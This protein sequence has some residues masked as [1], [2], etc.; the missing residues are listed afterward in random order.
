[1]KNRNQLFPW[2]IFA[3]LACGSHLLAQS[4]TL[5][6]SA[7]T[8]TVTA[9][10]SVQAVA[11]ITVTRTGG[12]TGAASISYTSWIGNENTAT[13]WNSS[14]GINPDLYSG[15]LTV[16]SGILNWAA[17][18]SAPKTFDVLLEQR[19]AGTYNGDGMLNL[20]IENASGATLGTTSRAMLTVKDPSPPAAGVLKFSRR[21]YFANRTTGTATITVSRSGGS[22]GTVGISY[23]TNATV[24]PWLSGFSNPLPP[25]ASTSSDYTPT[26]GT[27]SWGPGDLADKSFTIPLNVGG[28]GTNEVIGL[29]LSSPTGGAVLGNAPAAACT[30]VNPSANVV[31]LYQQG[32]GFQTRIWLPPAGTPL[33]GILFHMPG[34]SN[35]TLGVCNDY[36]W[37]QM[38]GSLGLAIM[39]FQSSAI[40]SEDA[41]G[42]GDLLNML[43]TAADYTGRAEL[44]NAPVIYTGFSSGGFCSNSS[45]FI[46]SRRVISYFSYKGG[47]WPVDGGN[48]PLQV[49]D[50]PRTMDAVQ[51]MIPGFYVTGNSDTTV[52]PGRSNI[53]F[54]PRRAQGAQVAYGVDWGTG[55][56]VFGAGSGEAMMW[57][58]LGEVVPLRF[59][60]TGR[61]V[62][63]P[64]AG[65]TV[66]LQDIPDSAGWI[67][68]HS[69]TFSTTNKDGLITGGFSTLPPITPYASYSG[70]KLAANWLPSATVA[71]AFQAFNARQTPVG[72]GN[73]NIANQ[74]LNTPLKFLS[75]ASLA[76][77]VLGQTYPIEINPRRVTNLKRIRFYEGDTLI[78]ERTAA[79]WKIDWTPS[80]A[81]VRTLTVIGTDSNNQ[82]IPAFNA[83]SVQ[84]LSSPG[85][86]Q[87]QAAT[88]EAFRSAGNATFVINRS[89]GKAGAVGATWAISGGTAVSGTDFSGPTSGSVTWADGD[90]TPKTISIPLL[91]STPRL[92]RTIDLTL[93]SLTG[94]IALAPARDNTD[95]AP[96]DTRRATSTITIHDDTSPLPSPWSTTTIG[97]TIG[98]GIP[99]EAS[100]FAENTFSL[101]AAT[102]QYWGSSDWL[103]FA[104]QPMTGDCSITARVSSMTAGG[105]FPRAG[106]M[107]RQDLS[108]TSAFCGAQAASGNT[109]V[110]LYRTTG[111]SGTANTSGPTLTIPNA[112]FRVTR[113][114]N[115]LTSFTSPNGSTWTQLGTP[116]TITMTGTVYVGLVW[117]NG[118]A[119]A[120]STEARFDNVSVTGTA[121]ATAVPVITGTPLAAITGYAGEY[122]SRTIVATGNPTPTFSIASGTLPAGLT[123]N[124]VTGVLSGSPQATGSTSVTIRA[125]NAVGTNDA[126]Q[127][128]SIALLVPPVIS[129]SA[130]PTTPQSQAVS[131]QLAASNS[132]T[133][134][135]MTG[136]SLP[137]GVSFNAATA[138]ISGTPSQTG[139]FRPVFTATNSAGTSSPKTVAM[140]IVAAL[141]PSV[142]YDFN[143]TQAD[144]NT[145]FL[146]TQ[147]GGTPTWASAGI[148]A[149]G[150]V[151]NT[152]WLAASS[153]TQTALWNQG[154]QWLPG[155]T[156]TVS[157]YFK[158]RVTAGSVAGGSSLRL[159]YTDDNL[160]ILTGA[161]YLSV[162]IN[163][164]AGDQSQLAVIYRQG[165]TITTAGPNVGTLVH[166]NWY[167]LI[168]TFTKSASSGSFD[169]VVSLK[170]WGADGQ[171]GGTVLGTSSSIAAT[172][173]TNVYD[174][175]GV[176]AGFVGTT[177]SSSGVQGFDS[178]SVAIPVP[179]PAVVPG[180]AFNA[181][182]GVT[183]S[184]SVAATGNPVAYTL[185]SGSLPA[186]LSLNTSTGAITGT[187]TASGTFAPLISATNLGGGESA[188]EAVNITILSGLD[189]YRAV[190]GLSANGSQDLLTPAGDGVANL[191]KYAFNMIG[192]GT[193]QA[194][195]L[196]T[197]NASVLTPSGSAGLP[198]VSLLPAPSSSL[199]LTFIRRKASSA[200][201]I[202]YTVEFSDALATWAVNP[203]ATESVTSLDATFERVTVTDSVAAPDKRF[204]RVK[205]TAP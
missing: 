88:P 52:E 28:T 105:S 140:N 90:A 34:T 106:V 47:D 84:T 77:L 172:A 116:Q 115:V 94:G 152:G 120:L 69:Y 143:S 154:F 194:S 188:A 83:V 171:T 68:P 50:N 174:S 16:S 203:S 18:D 196:T 79:P 3:F 59:P 162:G 149:T 29:Q 11:T 125:T 36:A 123:L 42:L 182:L 80:I 148:T 27:L 14:Q 159:G 75:P 129:T 101:R 198:Y 190:H 60:S 65:E 7:P 35:N 74:P 195:A 109:S 167:Q 44:I 58:Y 45:P 51:K 146:E 127:S 153:F 100:L 2:I 178:L 103:R 121:V 96:P 191:L 92:A 201:G 147:V 81:G 135:A 70:D 160:G 53:S 158:A 55:H 76:S 98:T 49:G 33:R 126:T 185:V 40:L 197:P 161:E 24:P 22:T 1:M 199:Q 99:G 156:S 133:S 192:S 134:W 85:F 91:N 37:Q 163:T 64:N 5:Q 62:P 155:Q 19:T 108:A 142:L 31:D 117:A 71:R 124:P 166:G 8:Y 93:H 165:G 61:T 187:P 114:G 177:N 122:L 200:P 118:S 141:T 102:D 25:A 54:A 43:R 138:T 151:G 6:F 30:I 170:S 181:S 113:V 72:G 144:F 56:A 137:T 111:G 38:A 164:T 26:S 32:M 130:F 87:F 168:G 176:Y 21:G 183:F 15:Q 48:F 179:P 107:I 139:S 4:G 12:S 57:S 128:I 39:G 17:G 67:S 131:Y 205:V 13:T 82:E 112:W 46:F 89:G 23:T 73:T 145:R 9:S 180:Q 41:A 157:V 150:G 169:V 63:G 97:S 78:G 202:S 104:M 175:P 184:Q 132:P 204:A 86:V 189:N 193:G 119:G 110:L 173:L 20:A 10:T 66:S 136:G 186:G 95:G